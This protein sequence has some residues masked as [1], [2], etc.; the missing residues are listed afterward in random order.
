MVLHIGART[1]AYS[2][3]KLPL[4]FC[5]VLLCTIPPPLGGGWGLHKVSTTQWPGGCP[6]ASA[7]QPTGRIYGDMDPICA[8][9]THRETQTVM[10]K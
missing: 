9:E 1:A 4:G 7:G 10:S 8:A 6:H 5:L 2:R 3:A